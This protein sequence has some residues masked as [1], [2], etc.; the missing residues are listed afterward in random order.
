MPTL[1]G[2]MSHTPLGDELICNMSF[3]P[4]ISAFDFYSMLLPLRDIRLTAGS[5]IGDFSFALSLL[6]YHSCTRLLATT[7]DDEETCYKKYPQARTHV[8][9]LIDPTTSGSSSSP[10]HDDNDNE[11][12]TNSDGEDPDDDSSPRVHPHVLFSVDARHLSRG[13]S[14]LTS[15]STPN[16]PSTNTPGTKLIRKPPFPPS[17][18]NTNG[19]GPWDVI[20]FNYP[21]VGGLSTNVNR[22]VRS[23]QALL[24]DFFKSCIPL[25]SKASSPSPHSRQDRHNTTSPYPD[26]DEDLNPDEDRRKREPGRIL[27]SIFDGEPYTL[28]NI[29]DLAR[30]C[31][32]KVLTSMKFPWS[33]FPGYRHARTLGNIEGKSKGKGKDGGWGEGD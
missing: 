31:G 17:H 23:N 13:G 21:H 5:F 28:W 25:L 1:E 16:P 15:L 26:T 19:E 33:E 30:H 22:Q 32:L 20:I 27:V 29:R 14:L 9:S 12:S 11:D 8:Q 24:V 10:R 7:F 6:N 18:R 2:I 3:S 4:E